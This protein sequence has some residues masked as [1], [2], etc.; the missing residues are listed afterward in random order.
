MEQQHVGVAEDAKIDGGIPVL[1]REAEVVL[2]VLL[3]EQLGSIGR[4]ADGERRAVHVHSARLVV[5][6][7]QVE[8]GG[9]P[10]ADRRGFGEL[11]AVP[12][13]RPAGAGARP[14]RA[15][16]AGGGWAPRYGAAGQ[17]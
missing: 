2:A 9:P 6:D 16:P 14:A 5:I 15:P 4:V 11:L 13:R 10:A 1:I 8:A 12:P 17:R 3:E 7:G